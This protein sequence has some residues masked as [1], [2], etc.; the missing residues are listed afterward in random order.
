MPRNQRFDVLF[1]AGEI[2]RRLIVRG[3]RTGD[4]IAPLGMTGTRK[5]QDVFVDYKLARACR[6]TWP[7][8]EA[9]CGLLWVPGMVRSRHALVTSA[10]QT[11]LRL[12]VQRDATTENTSLL[13]I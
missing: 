3:F 2:G 4:R 7:L 13:R 6:P 9:E 5:V 11:I 10:T 1:D 12:T 8:V